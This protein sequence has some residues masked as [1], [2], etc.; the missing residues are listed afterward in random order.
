MSY[1][2]PSQLSLDG[3][4]QH[5][6]ELWLLQLPLTVWPCAVAQLYAYSAP[7]CSKVCT[8]RSGLPL[9]QSN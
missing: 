3:A 5:P 2:L 9:V 4:T 1:V 7:Y 8:S 6:C